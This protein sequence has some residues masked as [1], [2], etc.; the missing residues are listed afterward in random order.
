MPQA[1]AKNNIVGAIN[2][3]VFANWQCITCVW[4]WYAYHLHV[5]HEP[6]AGYNIRTYHF[7][8]HAHSNIHT[9]NGQKKD[10]KKRFRSLAAFESNDWSLILQIDTHILQPDGRWLI[11]VDVTSCIYSLLLTFL[12]HTHVSLSLSGRSN[13]LQRLCLS[14]LEYN[15]IKSTL[16]RS[17]SSWKCNSVSVTVYPKQIA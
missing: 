15:D 12:S 2:Y 8:A 3:T 11:Y 6:P 5:T 14:T 17:I 13:Q 16:K 9:Q 1:Q 4:W 7:Y 10:E